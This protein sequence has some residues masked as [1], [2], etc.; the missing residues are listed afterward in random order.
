MTVAEQLRSATQQLASFGIEGGARD[1]RILLAH[2]LRMDKARLTL[3]MQDELGT[4]D[5]AH[6]RTLI[7]ARGQNRPVS[8]IVGGREFYGRWFNVTS[9]VLDPR[10][11]T[12]TLIDLALSDPFANVLDL[13][14][15]SGAI[16]VTLLAESQQ[17]VG[18]ATDIS[19]QALKIAQKNATALDVADRAR[20]KI[21]D[22]FTWVDG[23]FDLI[24]SNPPYIAAVEMPDLARDVQEFEPR[25]ALTDNA[26]GLTAYRNIA[27]GVMDYLSP[28]GRLLVEIGPKQAKAVSALF[29]NNGLANV[30]THCDLD[31]RDRV[32]SAIKPI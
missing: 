6:F 11:D 10:P 8:H 24:V 22:W 30:T 19:P 9:D 21:S 27:S 15:G 25:I 16:L 1:A 29:K 18:V 31:G 28:E 20:F 26:D 5:A 12:E 23:T 17:S 14:T 32:I 7:E 2:V 3:H 13:G 4:T